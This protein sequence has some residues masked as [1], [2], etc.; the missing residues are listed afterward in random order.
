M[1]ALRILLWCA[2]LPVAS[3]CDPVDY[4]DVEPSLVVLSNKKDSKWLSAKAMSHTRVHYPNEKVSWSVKDPSIATV[5]EKGRITPLK[6]GNTEVVAT[7]RNVKASVPV[8]VR[9]AEKMT[10]T[11]NPMTLTEGG[12]SQ[13]FQVKVFD[14]DGRELKDRT[15]TFISKDKEIVSMGQNAAFPVNPGQTQVEVRVEDL[16]QTLDVKVEKGSKTAKR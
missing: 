2:V 11:P 14:F 1:K 3:G 5:D 13:E 4:I 6:S 16:F 10:V 12:G 15:A 7:H 9:F 8:Q